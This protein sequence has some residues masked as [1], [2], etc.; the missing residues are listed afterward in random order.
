MLASFFISTTLQ[1]ANIFC[2]RARMDLD[3]LLQRSVLALNIQMP[4][5]LV[6]YLAL[7]HLRKS[8]NIFQQVFINFF[9]ASESQLIF[10]HKSHI[11]ISEYLVLELWNRSSANSAELTAVN[12][13]NL[14]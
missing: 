5:P 4:S 13:W 3:L 1:N 2:E 7:P 9:V 10:P 6:H 14:V 12:S 8:F 11:L